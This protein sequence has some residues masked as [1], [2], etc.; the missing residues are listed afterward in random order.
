MAATVTCA[1]HDAISARIELPLR[2]RWIAELRLATST[3]PTGAVTITCTEGLE[4][5]GTVQR[6]AV[7]LDACDVWIVGGAGG[8]AARVTSAY[9][10]AQLRDPLAAVLDAAGES[11]D[12]T[13]NSD[14]LGLPLSRWDCAGTA[15]ACL[16][17]LADEAGRQLGEAVNW[18]F[19]AS[20]ALWI[21]RESWPAGTLPEHA[22]VLDRDTALDRYLVGAETVT[23]LP[24]TDLTGVGKVRCS[25]HRLDAGRV[26]SELWV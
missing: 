26:R 10:S 11:L 4:L 3:A 13:S 12:S 5:H 8:L 9:R 25:V 22:Q 18:R 24:G 17:A 16:D 21:G 15:L 1:G 7:H 6:S 14:V 20:G 23:I 19:L 2:G